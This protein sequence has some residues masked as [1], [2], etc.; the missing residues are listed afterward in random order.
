MAEKVKKQLTPLDIIAV[1]GA[2]SLEES[3]RL[4]ENLR[5]RMDLLAFSKDGIF[6]TAILLLSCFDGTRK[7]VSSEMFTF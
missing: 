4:V 6:T 1:V 5:R 2:T 3:F 7:N